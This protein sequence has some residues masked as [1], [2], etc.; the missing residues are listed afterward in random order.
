M[1]SDYVTVWKKVGETPYDVVVKYRQEHNIPE[2]V[3]ICYT[4][5]LDPM[6]QGILPLLIGEKCKEMSDHL[7]KDKVYEA[8]AVLGIATDTYDAMGLFTD[9]NI[10]VV[11]NIDQYCHTLSSLSGK[12]FT[13]KFPPYSAFVVKQ[14]PIKG[15]LWWWAMEGRLDEIKDYPSKEVTVHNLEILSRSVISLSDYVATITDEIRSVK[16]GTNFRQEQIIARW[17]ELPEMM[18]PKIKFRAKVST[19]TYIRSLVHEAL[20]DLVP[21]HAHLITRTTYGDPKY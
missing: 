18:L 3:K 15:P 2:N 8:E 5:R 9:I 10:D 16:S 1:Q 19:G 14:P 13:Q 6:A 12:T 21:A 17:Q 4:G 7:A 11:D 20:P